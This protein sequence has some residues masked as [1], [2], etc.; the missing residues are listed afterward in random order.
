MI[1]PL[2][3]RSARTYGKLL[4]RAFGD[5]S[6]SNFGHFTGSVTSW[7]RSSRKLLRAAITRRCR[8][9]GAHTESLCTH[10]GPALAQLPLEWKAKRA[11]AIPGEEEVQ[12]Y[13][14]AAL[15]LPPGLRV[16]ALLPLALGL[17]AEEVCNL[18]REHVKR[19]IRTAE[20]IA[21]RKGGAE[22]AIPVAGVKG[23][24]SELLEVP[25][26]P[27]R[28]YRPLS[29][30][31]PREPWETVGEILSPKGYECQ[32]KKLRALVRKT[33]E[34]AGLTG[35]RPHL[36]RHAFAT[37]MNRDGASLATIQAAL[38][39]ANVATTMMYV[40]VATADVAKH[41]RDFNR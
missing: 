9:L 21:L 26:H 7:P 24:L 41:Q 37:R 12:A 10:C 19:A 13:E 6:P 31:K 11:V 28:G 32:Y 25:K 20:L 17:R 22:K 2:S 38:N 8:D 1:R 36:L 33:G 35:L 40:H 34:K 27:G 29:D 18:R 16:V 4:R 30:P 14:E 3:P 15:G 39:H 5:H 23:L